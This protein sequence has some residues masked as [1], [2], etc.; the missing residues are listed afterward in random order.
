MALLLNKS[1]EAKEIGLM[2]HLKQLE[3]QDKVKNLVHSEGYGCDM[4]R[5]SS[6]AIGLLKL[7]Q[8]QMVIADCIR[9]SRWRLFEYIEKYQPHVKIVRIVRNNSSGQ[10]AMRTGSYSFLLGYGFDVEQLRTCLISAL[11][12]KHRTCWL[13]AHGERCN[14]SCVDNFQSDEDFGEIE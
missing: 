6:A 14:R 5:D 8:Y 10:H 1:T 12:L 3:L 7:S 2:N 11:K 9:Y 4:P 13:L